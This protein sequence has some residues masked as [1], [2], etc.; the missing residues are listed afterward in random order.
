MGINF[1]ELLKT[2][3]ELQK[4]IEEKQ[5]KSLKQEIKQ[6][7]PQPMQKMLDTQEG[8]YLLIALAIIFVFLAVKVIG[9]A[10]NLFIRIGFI[11]AVAAALYFGYVYFFST[12]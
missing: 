2:K 6:Y 10:F 5:D 3:E 12:S 4:K 11:L 1:E 9:F 8:T 7:L